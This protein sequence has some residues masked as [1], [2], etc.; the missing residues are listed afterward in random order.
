MAAVAPT[1]ST[2]A[3]VERPSGGVA[4]DWRGIAFQGALLATLVTALLVI[5][6]V[7]IGDVIRTGMPV[8]R[9]RGADFIRSDLSSFA[10]RAGVWQGIVGSLSLMIFVVVIAVP[11]RDRGRRLHRGVRARHPAHAHASTRTSATSP[12]CPRSSTGSWAWRSS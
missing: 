1:S 6:T 11:A 12:A 4:T 5:L 7:L 3:A 8:F 9:E 10:F 2:T